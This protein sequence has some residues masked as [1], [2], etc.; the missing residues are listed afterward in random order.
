MENFGCVG[1]CFGIQREKGLALAE[2]GAE[3]FEARRNDWLPDPGQW[4]LAL[5]IFMT[6]EQGVEVTEVRGS[7]VLAPLLCCFSP[8]ALKVPVLP[9]TPCCA[10]GFFVCLVGASVGTPRKN[11]EGRWVTNQ[12]NKKQKHHLLS[13]FHFPIPCALCMAYK[14]DV[15]GSGLIRYRM[16]GSVLR[17]L[18]VQL[19]VQGK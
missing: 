15:P 2:S 19:M 13:R 14:K 3:M 16:P 18:G 17:S 12:S 9:S 4:F 11:S 5:R 7:T 6:F 10:L 1:V 8:K